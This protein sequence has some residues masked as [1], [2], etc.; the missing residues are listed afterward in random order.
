[1][2]LYN[3]TGG[4]IR[5]DDLGGGDWKAPRGTDKNG[6]L[7]YH[8]G[9][10]VVVF[11]GGPVIAPLAGTVRHSMPYKPDDDK[12]WTA[13]PANDGICIRSSDGLWDVFLWY[14]LPRQGII[15]SMV[16]PGTLVGTAE[17]VSA[18]YKIRKAGDSATMMDHIHV[19]IRKAGTKERVE[20]DL[21]A[22]YMLEA[23]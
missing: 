1:M 10:D 12:V 13:H 15:G 5:N 16:A 14:L 7:R 22:L 4:L 3:P 11:P 19:E 9:K 17:S 8:L 18:L 20:P 21:L 2:N 23:T 6:D